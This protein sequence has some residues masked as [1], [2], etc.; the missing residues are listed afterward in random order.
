[1]KR[2]VLWTAIAAGAL[3]LILIAL[4]FLIDPNSFRPTLESNLT[5]ALG[6]TVKL[7][8][9]KLS[10]LSGGVTASDLSIA[11]DPAYSRPPFIQAKQLKIAV[12]LMPLIFSRRLNVTGLTIHQPEITLIESPT[13]EWNFSGLGGTKPTSSAEAGKPLDLSVKLVKISDGRLSL[14]APGA[15]T[16]PLVLEHVNIEV[17]D[18]SSTAPFTFT[19]TSKVAG[20]GEIKMD[21]KA[22]PIDQRDAAATPAS[23]TLKVEQF[24]LAGSGWTQATPGMGGI[25]GLDGAVESDGRTARL[26]GKLKVEKLRLATGAPPAPH[27]VELDFGV[28]HNFKSRSGRISRGDIHIGSARATL[29]GTY[30]EQAGS[31]VLHMNLS[32]PKMPVPELAA[33]LPSI[34]MVLPAG[35]SLQGGTASVKL[36]MEGPADRLVTSGTIEMDNT[37]ISGFDLGTKMAV[38]QAL[39]GMPRSPNTEIQTLSG[40]IRIAPEGTSAESLRLI[41]PSIGELSGGGTVSPAKELDFKMTAKVHTSGMMAAISN[42]ALP[43]TVAGT[44]SAPVFRPDVRSVVSEK[45]K[46]IGIKEAGGLIKGLLGG[47]K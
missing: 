45:A 37:T 22:G 2:I 33:M 19:L 3:V 30:A 34:G 36:T 39:A 10:I 13:G 25:V 41:V 24:D 17:R 6:R 44:A 8:D 5:R 15:R 40:N 28:D 11:D 12:E 26:N 20:G 38:I 46:S 31:T 7:G 32:G 4:P 14:G 18:F 27:T 9:L 16:R 21:G 23:A 42:A 29:T 1:M 43:F 47:K 35:A